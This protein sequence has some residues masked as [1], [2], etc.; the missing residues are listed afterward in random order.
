MA[1]LKR[2][3]V[4]PLGTIEALALKHGPAVADRYGID[5]VTR[6]SQ[7]GREIL[8]GLGPD[9]SLMRERLLSWYGQP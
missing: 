8:D 3:A 1:T 6:W 4:E 2:S 9:D 7:H 5:H